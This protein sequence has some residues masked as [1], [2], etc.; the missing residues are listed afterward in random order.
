ME[1]LVPTLLPLIAPY[2]PALL[3]RDVLDHPHLLA[4]PI[5]KRFP[6]AI[7]FAD[8]SGFTS[9]TEALSQ[10]SAEGVEELTRLLNVYL[11]RMI[12]LIEAEGGQ[13]VKFGGDSVTGLFSGEPLDRSTRRAKQAADRMQAIMAEFVDLLT[14]IGPVSLGLKIGLGAGE[15]V[16]VRVGDASHRRYEYFVAGSALEQA[17]R[18]EGQAVANETRLS[19]EAHAV[20]CP[21]GLRSLPAV[22][23]GYSAIRDARAVEDS[24]LC[25]LPRPIRGWLQQGL[26]DWA[27]VLH[28]MS[29]LFLGVRGLDYDLLESSA[30]LAALYSM[31]LEII[32]RY[33]GTLAR[34]SADDKG[35]V[36]L[37]LF[38]APPFAHEDDPARAVRCALDVQ[39]ALAEQNDQWLDLAIGV[40]TGRVYAGPVGGDTRREYTVMG[41]A[42]N[43]AAR[44]AQGADAGEIHCD[45]AT[46]SRARG[47]CRFTSVAAM[48]IRGRAGRT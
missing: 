11:G 22:P 24:L 1:G 19:A 18:A 42:V 29:V 20:I 37:V 16:T 13:V 28:P 8:V 48:R 47:T 26:H 9:L 27:A 10:E 4:E 31:A 39:S 38:G 23:I 46:F 6:A 3:L 25:Y 44:L 12:V 30:Q 36:M 15:A 2:V 17:L 45:Y 7:L 32:Y 5:S 34:L 35:T 40:A 21:D 33:E 14:S 41:N 43:L